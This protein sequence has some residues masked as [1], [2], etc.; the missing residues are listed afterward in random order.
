MQWT[1]LTTAARILLK[2]M[3]FAAWSWAPCVAAEPQDSM[4]SRQPDPESIDQARSV[5]EEFLE[6]PIRL[7][8]SD[9]SAF[10]NLR[11]SIPAFQFEYFDNRFDC[12]LFV[13]RSF[14]EFA[15]L[16]LTR[17]RTPFAYLSRQ[18]ILRL[19]RSNPGRIQAFYA[20]GVQVECCLRENAGWYTG[21]ELN[22]GEKNLLSFDFAS[23]LTTLKAAP[24]LSF[25]RLNRTLRITDADRIVTTIVL[26]RERRPDVFPMVSWESVAPNGRVVGARNF[27]AFPYH[28]R[29]LIPAPWHRLRLAAPTIA[30]DVLP[31][32]DRSTELFLPAFARDLLG[33]KQVDEDQQLRETG[34]RFL[35]LFPRST[36]LPGTE[37]EDV[38]RCV[39]AFVSG[40]RL[41]EF[42]ER[43]TNQLTRAVIDP[44]R[45]NDGSPGAFK[46]E[47]LRGNLAIYERGLAVHSVEAAYGPVLTGRIYDVLENVVCDPSHADDLRV[48]CLS[49]L[50]QIGVLPG[51]SLLAN[52]DRKLGAEANDELLLGLASVKAQVGQVTERDVERL[53]SGLSRPKVSPL[54]R[55]L[56]VEGLVCVDAITQAD[57]PACVAILEQFLKPNAAREAD[58]DLKRSLNIAACFPAGRR[59]L[60]QR[61]LKNR[62]GLPLPTLLFCLMR[63][64][65]NDDPDW[66]IL[67]KTTEAIA[68]DE[69]AP[70]ADR[71]LA[72]R[73]GVYRCSGPEVSLQFAKAAFQSKD[74][75]LVGDAVWLIGQK[76]IGASLLTEIKT[77]LATD[78]PKHHSSVASGLA[79]ATYAPPRSE[80][81]T[82]FSIV[83]LALADRDALVRAAGM[84]V[85]VNFK[86]LGVPLPPEILD[87]VG[88]RMRVEQTATALN[89]MLL[90]LPEL[91]DQQ[92]PHRLP[93]EASVKV[94]G[95]LP[96]AW[97]K[98]HSE[99]YRD[100]ALKWL[101]SRTK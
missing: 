85:L 31:P 48:A 57:E 20:G 59:L 10:P 27:E 39:D 68:L 101:D 47:F 21:I 97:W 18:V 83:D 69:H 43:I 63:R 41:R 51:S 13:E 24:E 15:V 64:M 82:L 23:Y 99:E 95:Q 53:R 52:F 76:G 16:M 60:L 94:K 46:K 86:K 77:V 80:Y 91:T 5:L 90:S 2:F 84:R 74:D 33:S 54:G 79:R 25:D 28:G 40:S 61:F 92:Y 36:N 34:L 3:V 26:P 55:L 81:P 70:I 32:D 29:R 35:E 14:D 44:L 12:R 78:G 49:L 9:H 37:F 65:P 45:M 87:R 42:A 66:P 98:A 1:S 100:H 89:E 30:I 7:D 8:G 72:G 50:G 38:E 73:L 96:A 19:D 62:Q 67:L 4:E 58:R 11:T 56:C 22:S 6:Q 71:L 88:A 17:P 75:E 93:P